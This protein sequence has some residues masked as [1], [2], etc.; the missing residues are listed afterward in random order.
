MKDRMPHD[1]NVDYGVSIN[2][3]IKVFVVIAVYTVVIVMFT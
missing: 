1:Q 3:V 2:S